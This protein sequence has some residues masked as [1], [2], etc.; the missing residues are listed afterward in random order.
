MSEGESE[1]AVPYATPQGM[2]KVEKSDIIMG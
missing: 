2:K 1:E